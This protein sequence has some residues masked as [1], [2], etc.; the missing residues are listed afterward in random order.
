[1]LTFLA[2][3]GLLTVACAIPVQKDD[4]RLEEMIEQLYGRLMFL[5]AKQ[6]LEELEQQAELDAASV[7]MVQLEN[8]QKRD[9]IAKEVQQLLALKH[10]LREQEPGETD[11]PRFNRDRRVAA[12]HRLL[13][14]GASTADVDEEALQN[15]I[16]HF[17]KTL[18]NP[19]EA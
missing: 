15:Y 1:M 9:Q 12:L 10:L 5:R 16:E 8:Q 13:K 14:E 3:F 6:I 17:H 11:E 7:E 4:E 18:H 19:N 2:L